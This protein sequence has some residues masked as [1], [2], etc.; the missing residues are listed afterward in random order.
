MTDGEKHGQTDLKSEIVIF[1]IHTY[2]HMF[3][4]FQSCLNLFSLIIKSNRV[5]TAKYSKKRS[6]GTSSF[7]LLGPKLR[8]QLLGSL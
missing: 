1:L 3:R 2:I 7:C 6:A 5:Y 8:D 4:L